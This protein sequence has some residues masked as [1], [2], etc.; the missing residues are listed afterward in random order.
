[1]VLKWQTLKQSQSIDQI[2]RYSYVQ[3]D[4]LPNKACQDIARGS[5]FYNWFQ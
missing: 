2:T 4:W 3:Q 1:M 5:V